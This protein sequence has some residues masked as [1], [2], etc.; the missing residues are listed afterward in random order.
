MGEDDKE[1]NE[2]DD[3]CIAD[4][5]GKEKETID[6]QE[7]LDDLMEVLDKHLK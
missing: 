1:D 6:K 5:K 4:T 2:E 3:N 7:V